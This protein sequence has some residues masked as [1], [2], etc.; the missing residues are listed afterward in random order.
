MSLKKLAKEIAIEAVK[1]LTI[2]MAT[3]LGQSMAE[4]IAPSE[5]EKRNEQE[6]RRQD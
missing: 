6:R 1:A 4:R 5:G 2:S 3:S